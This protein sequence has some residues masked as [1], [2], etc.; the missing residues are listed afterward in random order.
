MN[1]SWLSSLLLCVMLASASVTSNAAT[2]IELDWQSP[3]SVDHPLVGTIHAN[4]L[5]ISFEDL[6]QQ[7]ASARHILIGEKHEQPRSPAAG[8]A[9]A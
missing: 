5:T 6:V 3:L 8:S 2:R 9:L 4:R 1:R 7:M